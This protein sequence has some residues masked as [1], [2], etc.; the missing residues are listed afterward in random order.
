MLLEGLK[1]TAA[2]EPYNVH[3]YSRTDTQPTAMMHEVS[4]EIL[5]L[6]M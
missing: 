1:P 5:L 4:A 2:N 3:I 6:L